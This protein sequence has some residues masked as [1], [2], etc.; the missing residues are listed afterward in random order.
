M[1]NRSAKCTDIRPL[2]LFVLVVVVVAYGGAQSTPPVDPRIRLEISVANKQPEFDVGEIIPLQLAFSSTVPDHYQVNMAQYD[3]SGR[4]NYEHF[5]VSPADGAVDPL[6]TNTGGMG[7]LTNFKFLTSEPWTIKLNLNEWVRFTR[8]GEYRLV[9][10]SNRVGARD[11]S[12]PF[13]AS[14]AIARSN[15][16]TLK[17]VPANPSWQKQVF[18]EAVAALDVPVKQPEIERDTTARRRAFEILRFLGSAD[19]AREMAKRMRGEDSG[20]LD[21]VCMLGLISSPE[22][23]VARSALGEALADPDRPIDAN[24]L[25]TLR[26]INSDP[27]AATANWQEDQRKVVEELIAALPTKRGK[28]LSISLSTAL[29]EAWD[30]KALPQRTTHKLVSQLV[31]I[32]D[33]LPLK[34]QNTLLTFRW[35]R[36]AGPAMLPVLRLYA[37]SYRDFTEMRE[38]NAYNSLALSGSALRHWYELDPVGAR[39]AII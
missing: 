32:F 11:P 31:S 5:S 30:G 17:I 24:F 25:Y 16:I 33:Q 26:M 12:N 34:E 4:M 28:A 38:V 22:R 20:G 7:G 37:Q 23:E 21:Y 2:F 29:Y 10:S 19:A 39:P 14:P 35:D 9:V 6:P 3:R 18:N 15:E 8:P 27:S 1:S 13:G 36:I